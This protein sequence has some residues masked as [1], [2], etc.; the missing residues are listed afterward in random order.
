MEHSNRKIIETRKGKVRLRSPE[1]T[2]GSDVWDLIRACKPLDEN[3]MYCNLIQCDHFAGTSVLAERDG[4]IIGWISAHIPPEKPD[5]LFVW[6]VAVGA[7][8]RGMG[9]AVHMLDALVEREACANVSRI[10]TTITRSNDASWALFRKFA[11]RHKARLSDKPHFTR[12]QHFD[13]AH[14]T[15]HLVSIDMAVALQNAA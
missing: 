4:Q 6:Q 11:R 10:E 3:S 8:A 5:T 15:E 12:D 13:G 9:L 7:S 14:A 2:D 1:T